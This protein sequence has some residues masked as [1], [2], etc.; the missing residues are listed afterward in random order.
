MAVRNPVCKEKE[1]VPKETANRNSVYEKELIFQEKST[2]EKFNYLDQSGASDYLDQSGD[3]EFVD[4]SEASKHR[5]TWSPFWT[6]A[7]W[8]S[9]MLPVNS[10]YENLTNIV[11]SKLDMD[12]DTSKDTE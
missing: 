4:K 10:A 9:D 11:N 1:L 3:S 12:K 2:K 7:H 6:C 8:D 5:Q